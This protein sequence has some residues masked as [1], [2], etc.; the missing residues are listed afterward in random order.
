MHKSN[1]SAT[2]TLRGT[3]VPRLGLGTYE[4]VGAACTRAVQHALDIG[5]RHI[6]TAQA[7]GN[8]AA[9]GK[10]LASSQVPRQEIFLT[11]KVWISN[12]APGRL[13]QA[14]EESLRQLGT[15]YIDLL[16]LHWPQPSEPLAGT[17]HMMTRLREEG[18]IHQLGVSNF[19][20]GLLRQ[21]IEL[22][23]LFCNQVEYHPYLAQEKLLA[24]ARAHNLLF[25]AYAPLANG[26][27]LKDPVLAKIARAHSKSVGQVVLRWL[28]DQEQVAV[29]PKAA[30]AANRV[31]NFEIFDFSLSEGE[32]QQI[33]SLERGLRI[34]D[35]SWA[36]DWA[37]WD[38]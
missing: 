24:M 31:S 2:L 15:E 5:Y 16:L 20:P 25:T 19:P 34:Y 14:T 29:I 11:T 3:T 18:K 12:F 22:A 21:A 37:A 4:I 35:P 13:R 27:V 32:H 1:D 28:L 6:D 26:R 8:E 23:P 17:L 38:E 33:A 7:Y 36:P 9:V 30:S 10:G